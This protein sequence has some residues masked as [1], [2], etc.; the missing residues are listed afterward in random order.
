M[1]IRVEWVGYGREAAEALRAEIA[2][3]KGDDALAPVTVVVPSNHVGVATRRL[4]A[5]GTLGPTCRHGVGLVAVSF[6]TPY[7]L[8]E[9]LGAPALAA[10]GRRPVSTPVIAAAMRASLA[11]EPGLFA[12]SPSTPPPRPR[13]SRPTASCARSRRRGSTRSPRTG[14]AA[15]D[16]VRLHRATRERLEPAWYDEQD[17]MRSAASVL[18]SDPAVSAELGTVVM[19]L[20][21]RLTRHAQLLF[22]AIATASDVTVLAGITGDPRADADVVAAVR[23]LSPTAPGPPAR[24]PKPLR[25]PTARRSSS[26]PTPTRRCGPRCGG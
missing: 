14:A 25:R 24:R 5:S 10:T 18:A 8:A 7:R 3:T 13:S 22:D 6:V 4:L 23:H 16:V 9:L 17:L 12:P 1:A 2:R 21:Q 26:S 15:A 20:P 19:Y 11:E